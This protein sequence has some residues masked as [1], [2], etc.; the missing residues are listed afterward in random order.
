MVL[1]MKSF[2]SDNNAG[3]CPE[4]IKAITEANEGHVRAYG[5]DD[6]TERAREKFKETFG[7]DVET[8]FVFNGTA[9]NVLSIKSL[10]NSYNAVVCADTAHIYSDECGAPESLTGC[11]LL[12]VTTPDG[13]LTPELIS[14]YL[15]GRGDQHH[16]QPQVISITQSTE[17]GTVYSLAE[18]KALTTFA[19]SQNL[20]VHMDGARISNAVASLNCSFKE[21]TVDV[22]IDVLSFGGTKN[23]LI[24]GEAVVFL[25]KKMPVDFKY[26][27]KQFM[28]LSS[29]MRFIAVQFEALLKDDLWK[30]N[31]LQA[32]R[33]AQRLSNGLKE[34]KNAKVCYPVQAN[35][36]FVQ[37]PEEKIKVLQEKF[38]FYVWNEKRSEVRWMTSFDTTEKDVDD[39]LKALREEL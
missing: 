10:T 19:H 15:G 2:A 13:K 16:V 30:R 35:G 23:G 6:F 12:P 36:V 5:D 32:N 4:M 8:F 25:N 7:K 21:A 39:F 33:M 3:A 28:Q 9:A 14:N 29:K 1:L 37:I 24:G 34:I 26:Y 22:G 27:R 17:L 11:K 18:L 38:F 31:A 20:F